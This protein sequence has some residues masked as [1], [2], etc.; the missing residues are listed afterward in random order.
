MAEKKF[1]N[2]NDEEKEL[3]ERRM[4]E[5]KIN[6]VCIFYSNSYINYLILQN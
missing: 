2:V 4:Q 6:K 5:A 1:S 3:I